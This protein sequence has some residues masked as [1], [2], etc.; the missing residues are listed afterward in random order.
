MQRRHVHNLLL[1]LQS[2]GQLLY[3]AHHLLLLHLSPLPRSYSFGGVGLRVD[4]LDLGQTLLQ[5]VLDA[6]KDVVV[7][8]FVLGVV[9]QEGQELIRAV[10]LG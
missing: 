3:L 7:L 6:K 9:L 4:A 2:T 5:L 10:G 1:G 8:L